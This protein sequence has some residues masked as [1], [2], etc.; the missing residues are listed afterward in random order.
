MTSKFNQAKNYM[1]FG[2]DGVKLDSMPD[3]SNANIK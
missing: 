1:K 2:I 3:Y